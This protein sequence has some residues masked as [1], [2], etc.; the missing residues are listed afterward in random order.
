MDLNIQPGGIHG[1]LTDAANQPVE[2]RM[3]GTDATIQAAIDR[4]R[5][6]SRAAACPP[7][8]GTLRPEADGRSEIGSTLQ[9]AQRIG[10][11]Q[12]RLPAY[13]AG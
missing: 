2:F 3:M 12:L 5:N 9:D 8:E 7:G 1:A 13:Q 11:G 10:P 6:P 4:P